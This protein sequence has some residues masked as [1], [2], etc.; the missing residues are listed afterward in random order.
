M[1]DQ[2]D[3]IDFDDSEDENFDSLIDHFQGSVAVVGAGVVNEST[4]NHR[5]PVNLGSMVNIYK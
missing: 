4:E 2:L 1:D 3:E 5:Q